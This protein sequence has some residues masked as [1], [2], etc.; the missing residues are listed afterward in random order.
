[1]L[2]LADKMY[3]LAQRN[4]K[5]TIRE[6]ILNKISREAEEGN[7]DIRFE[8][9]ELNE[10]DKKALVEEG[11]QLANYKEDWMNDEYYLIS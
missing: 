8:L 4:R 5:P 10:Y 6:E 1:M 9:D 2:K 3:T 11:F 7:F